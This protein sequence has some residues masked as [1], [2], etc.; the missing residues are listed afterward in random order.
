MA[1]NNIVPGDAEKRK[2]VIVSASPV[3]LLLSAVIQMYGVLFMLW[4]II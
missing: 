3:L 1:E 2:K 4:L